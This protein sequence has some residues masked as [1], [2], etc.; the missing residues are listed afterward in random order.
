MSQVIP[1]LRIF[2]Y[3]KTIQFYVDWLGFEIVWEHKPEGNPVYMKISKGDAVIDLSEHHGDCSPGAKI[4]IADFKGLKAFHS[5]LATK[6]Y[7]YMNPGLE[8]AEWNPDI[9]MMTVI[10]PFYNQLTFEEKI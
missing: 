1:I 10:D 8:R 2:D 4:I 7:K 6:N 9:L 5:E 3:T